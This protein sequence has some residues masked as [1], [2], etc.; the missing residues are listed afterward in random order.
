MSEYRREQNVLIEKE[1]K[2]VLENEKLMW[3][4]FTFNPRGKKP[5]RKDFESKF[6]GYLMWFEFVLE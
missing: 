2:S 4:N 5:S 1:G 6:A 3:K